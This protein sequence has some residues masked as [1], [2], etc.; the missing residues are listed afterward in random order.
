MIRPRQKSMNYF[1]LLPSIVLVVVVIIFP[2]VYAVY[3]SFF[4][5]KFAFPLYKFVGLKLYKSLIMSSEYWYSIER[6]FV[7]TGFSLFFQFI[8]GMALALLLNQKFVGRSLVRALFVLPWIIPSFIIVAVWKWMLNDIYGIVNYYLIKIGIVSEA[9]NFFGSTQ[10]AMPTIVAMNVWHGFPL[11]MILL[12][13]G[14]MSI[15]KQLYEAARIDGA[16]RVMQFFHVTLPSLRGVILVSLLLRFIWTFTF[17]DIPYLSTRGG[18]A[19]ATM[20][21]AV[22]TY[23]VGFRELYVSKAAAIALTAV[24][25][26]TVISI[27]VV[28][29]FGWGGNEKEV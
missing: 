27:A 11:F 23:I 4:N 8:V 25:V 15:P 29:M 1:F 21:L 7:W 13:A 17:F 20:T 9:V 14:L 2:L 18:P 6:T 28:R 26:M 5:M 24:I 22:K 12:L 19:D 3:L 16:N 10:L